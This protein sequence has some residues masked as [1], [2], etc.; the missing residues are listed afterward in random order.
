MDIFWALLALI[1]S[2]DHHRSPFIN[3]ASPKKATVPFVCGGLD[4][5][6]SSTAPPFDSIHLSPDIGTLE[7][8]CEQPASRGVNYLRNHQIAVPTQSVDIKMTT[9]TYITRTS[10]RPDPQMAFTFGLLAANLAAAVFESCLYGILLILFVSTMY[11][12]GRRRRAGRGGTR[13]TSPLFV[14]IVALFAMV[15]A[16]WIMVIFQIFYAFVHLGGSEPA[17]TFYADLSQPSELIK[18]I[19]FAIALLIGDGLIIQRLW[20]IW[21]KKTQILIFP[22]FTWVGMGMSFVGIVYQFSKWEPALRGLPFL[23]DLKPWLT[24]A[25]VFSFATS[26]YSTALIASKIW[27]INKGI[28][29][30]SAGTGKG[31]MPILAIIIESAALQTLWLMVTFFS[32]LLTADLAFTVTD[33]FPTIVAICNMLIHCRVGLGWA[34]GSTKTEDSVRM[35]SRSLDAVW[36]VGLSIILVGY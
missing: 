10:R 29:A 26:I 8:L 18:M 21:G 9:L 1:Y 15:T 33:P 3:A 36:C 34:Q 2:T 5:T 30:L 25:T 7:L 13:R 11:F 20:V 16:H 35:K 19:F 12:W 27:R 6:P 24:M 17:D 4:H 22:L 31:M 23:A 14:G 32:V 28:R